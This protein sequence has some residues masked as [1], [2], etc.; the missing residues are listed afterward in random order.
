AACEQARFVCPAAFREPELIELVGLLRRRPLQAHS[1][2]TEIGEVFATLLERRGRPAAGTTPA[3]VLAL[4]NRELFSAPRSAGGHARV[5]ALSPSDAA[6]MK[7]T[8]SV[9]GPKGGPP[10]RPVAAAPT[11][12]HCAIALHVDLPDGCL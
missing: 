8:V 12:N 5:V 7:T 11:Q 4:P 2:A 3:I 10:G 1:G 9:S 6:V